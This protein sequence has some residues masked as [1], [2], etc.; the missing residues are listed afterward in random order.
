MRGSGLLGEVKERIFFHVIAHNSRGRNAKLA[1]AKE[2]H[3]AA[4]EAK[5]LF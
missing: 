1:P 4:A 3:V 2:K 5:L